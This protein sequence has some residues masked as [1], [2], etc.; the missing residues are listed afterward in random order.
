MGATI[1]QPINNSYHMNN[2]RQKLIDTCLSAGI[3][4][5]TSDTCAK[6]F[7]V[8]YV[9]GNNEYMTHCVPFLQDCKYIEQRF[10]VQGGE[11]PDGHFAFLLQE[12]VKELESYEEEHKNE[13][14]TTG[15]F[16]RHIPEW[17]KELF[18]VRYGIKLIN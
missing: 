8:L 10:N 18:K 11:T 14:T 12:Y 15:V 7:A 16:E 4:W 17:A 1:Y 13:R 5:M 2:F 9:H 6:V 3:P